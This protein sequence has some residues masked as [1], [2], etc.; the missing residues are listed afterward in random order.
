VKLLAAIAVLTFTNCG[1][2]VAGKGTL[3]PKE[4]HTIAVPA[5]NNATAR[6]RL[7]DDLPRD[8]ARE[9]LA[10][11]RYRVVADPNDADAIFTG[12][13]LNYSSYPTIIDGGRAAGVQVIVTVQAR[14]TGRATGQVL[15]DR[16]SLESRERYEVS[17]DQVAYFDES[18]AAI[19]RVSRDVARSLV[20]AVLENF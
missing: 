7:S 9:F 18:T 2:H 4:I 11:T 17:I 6:S 15:F 8:I 14:L 10:R 20:S 3:L 1:Y 5:F 12:A 19:D 16:P 13:I